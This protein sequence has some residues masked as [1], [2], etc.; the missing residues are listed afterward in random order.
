MKFNFKVDDELVIKILPPNTE[1]F[2]AGDVKNVEDLTK[3]ANSIWLAF[4]AI[5]TV[6]YCAN[7]DDECKT[8]D[9]YILSRYYPTI[10]SYKTTESLKIVY[11]TP[12]L[13]KLD[14]EFLENS[15]KNGKRQSS[16]YTDM[17]DI[18]KI[19]NKYK[20]VDGVAFINFISFDDT[21]WHDE[22]CLFAKYS[23]YPLVLYKSY[24][25]DSDTYK[26]QRIDEI[27]QFIQENLNEDEIDKYARYFGLLNIKTYCLRPEDELQVFTYVSYKSEVF[28]NLR[29]SAESV[30]RSDTSL[31]NVEKIKFYMYMKDIPFDLDFIQ[32]I[33]NKLKIKSIKIEN[34]E[35]FNNFL[36]I[37]SPKIEE[38]IFKIRKEMEKYCYSITID[39]FMKI[40][41]K[42]FE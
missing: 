5:D 1:L 32:R 40:V 9:N 10:A 31:E 25:W 11:I 13:V 6:Y 21:V 17:H 15:V 22:I 38:L 39:E 2:R 34:E 3:N 33:L 16:Y 41:E 36:N 29:G 19:R 8:E 37:E 12:D 26:K 35:D 24:M 20:D 4:K 30:S 23:N 28:E 14:S 42:Y 18:D 27:K 7:R